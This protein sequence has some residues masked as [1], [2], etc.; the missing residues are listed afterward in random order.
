MSH[1]PRLSILQ[2]SSLKSK[3][4]SDKAGRHI[5]VIA[6]PKPEL[7][8]EYASKSTVHVGCE[9]DHEMIGCR[10]RCFHHSRSLAVCRGGVHGR[11]GWL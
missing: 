11:K 9:I 3:I 2:P 5:T 10:N 1:N 4:H 8:S 6:M 7:A